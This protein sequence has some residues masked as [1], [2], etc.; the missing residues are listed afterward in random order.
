MSA[1]IVP[2]PRNARAA[3]ERLRAVKAAV[4][5]RA[6]ST[7]AT[8]E[9]QSHAV[10]TALAEF[11]RTGSASWAIFQGKQLLPQIARHPYREPTP[12]LDAA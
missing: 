5:E 6:K 12:P 3:G 2:F 7:N 8:L 11:Q 4:V 10:N 9:Q 1:V